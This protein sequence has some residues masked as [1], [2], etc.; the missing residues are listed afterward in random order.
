ML[1]GCSGESAGDPPPSGG[2][3]TERPGDPTDT[4]IPTDPAA[5]LD[6]WP[7]VNNI[8]RSGR[9]YF[10]GQPDEDSLVRLI[11][12]EGVR[13]VINIRTPAEESGMG[14]NGRAIADERG[15]RYETIP[16]S[17]STFSR[18]DVDRFAEIVGSS[19]G[20]IL[21]HCASS[22]RVG[23]LWAAY[24]TTHH[25]I[26]IEQALEIGRS[27][28][29]SRDSMAEAARRVADESPASPETGGG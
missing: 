27:A 6:S 18:A 2:A 5:R 19:D 28:G 16:V 15:A 24:L 3:P 7:G 4:A 25:N 8:F 20:P 14:V 11:D 1:Q 26:P 13:T 29:L 10:A 12:A 17:P 9:F 22:N 23:G 21:V